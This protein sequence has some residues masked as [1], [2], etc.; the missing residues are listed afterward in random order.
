MAY[1]DSTGQLSITV[2][3]IDV[4]YNGSSIIFF[5]IG[6]NDKPTG[7]AFLLLRKAQHPTGAKAA[8][9]KVERVRTGLS[10]LGQIACQVLQLH[11]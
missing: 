6:K 5:F 10:Q 7:P 9:I 8:K 4:C 1:D 2:V 11:Q 3:M